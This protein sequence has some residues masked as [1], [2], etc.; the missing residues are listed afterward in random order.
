[1]AEEQVDTTQES[2]AQEEASTSPQEQA[3]P[4]PALDLDATVK[5]DG[6]EIPIRD[7]VAAREEAAGLKE[8]AANARVLVNPGAASD[9]ERE[10]AIRYLMTQEGYPPSEIDS[11]VEWTRSVDNEDTPTTP[12]PTPELDPE[13]SWQQQQAETQMAEQERQRMGDIEDR[14]QRLGAEMMRKELETAIERTMATSEHLQKL[15]NSEFGEDPSKRA[16]ILRSEVE[17]EVMS[18]LRR[19]RSSGE[20]F[21]KRWFSEESGRAAQ[22]VYDKF[23]SVIGDPDKIQRAP[24]TAAESDELIRKAP[25]EAPKFEKGDDMGT[26]KDK[27]HE[28]TIDHLMRGAAEAEA[29]GESKA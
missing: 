22:S 25:V 17:N 19:R 8:Y 6:Q 18:N 7:L 12:K 4:Q 21:D 29:G 13:K 14:Q 1:M 5:I 28:Y 10:Q 9:T 2:V 11:Y 16:E 26:I 20:H 3:T 15:L 23:R 24:E 27:I